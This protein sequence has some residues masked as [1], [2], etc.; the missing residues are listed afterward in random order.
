[1]NQ[2]TDNDIINRF[3]RDF[4]LMW[5]DFPQKTADKSFYRKYLSGLVDNETFIRASKFAEQ[6]IAK[7]KTKR[8]NKGKVTRYILFS[9][10]IAFFAM[11]GVSEYKVVKNYDY[12]NKKT[13]QVI[14]SV[15]ALVLLL[16]GM[17]LC[18][19]V[20]SSHAKDS[21]YDEKPE[22][23]YNR[24]IVRYF[25]VLK[26]MYPE[27]SEKYLQI[28]NQPDMEMARTIYSLLIVNMPNAEVK[29]LNTIALSVNWHMHSN[30]IDTMRDIEEKL[31][32]AISIIESALQ[33]HPELQKAVVD[34][35]SCKV[36]QNFFV[37]NQS[38]KNRVRE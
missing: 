30:K 16:C 10:M 29:K 11:V 18:W 26:K 1:M 19:L 3:Q 12:I 24:L 9:L 8:D 32:Q 15:S 6:T 31:K 34:A 20:C 4:D 35:Y 2:D 7:A 17:G 23:F 14:F 13:Q 21:Q 37:V 5:P 22:I 28:C 38:K 36:P 25:D 27:L 33:K